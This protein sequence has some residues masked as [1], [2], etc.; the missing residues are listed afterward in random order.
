MY[1]YRNL[2]LEVGFEDYID[3]IKGLPSTLFL[4][5]HPGA[6]GLLSS[7]VGLLIGVGNTR[8]LVVE[9]IRRWLSML[10]LSAYHMLPQ[11]EQLGN[12]Y[13]K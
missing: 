3:Y 1:I 11:D 12:M 2:E 7:W 9:L 5:F 8:D 6:F 10:F 4:K 13:L